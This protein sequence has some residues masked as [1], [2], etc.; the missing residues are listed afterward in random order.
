MIS[1]RPCGAADTAF[2]LTASSDPAEVFTSLAAQCVP[3][4]CDACTIDLVDAA[5]TLTRI[6]DPAGASGDAVP[7][8]DE[9]VAAAMGWHVLTVPFAL[10]AVAGASAQVAAGEAEP[11]DDAGAGRGQ[12]HGVARFWWREHTPTAR[13]RL[14]GSLLVEHAVQTVAR[15]VS[16]QIARAA[17]EQAENLQIALRNSR[18][19]GAAI[20]I[21]MALHK[22]TEQQ[23]FDLLCQASQRAHRKLR[24]IARTVIDTGWLD[25]SLVEGT[26]TRRA[27]RP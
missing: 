19:I 15:R 1:T 5:G 4:W 26:G 9:G 7:T 2:V 13:D 18:H 17:V 27:R 14:T 8:D 24:D 23:A 12:P 10:S 25:P 3:A 6:A 20:G 22:I 11:D 21:L 16:D